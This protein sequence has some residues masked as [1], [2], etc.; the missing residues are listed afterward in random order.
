MFGG[1]GR[2]WNML[3]IVGVV[4]DGEGFWRMLE[5]TVEYFRM[6][7]VGVLGDSDPC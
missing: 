1:T 3:R 2:C 5:G 4:W 6:L 7:D